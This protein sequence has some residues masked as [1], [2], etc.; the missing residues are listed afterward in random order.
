MEIYDKSTVSQFFRNFSLD[1]SANQKQ[2]ISEGLQRSK[3]FYSKEIKRGKHVVKMLPTIQVRIIV[4]G[5]WQHF[6]KYAHR[7]YRH[8][9]TSMNSQ[10]WAEWTR[11]VPMN[12]T[13]WK[14]KRP[15]GLN[16]TLRTL[17]NWGRL[18][19]GKV[20]FTKEEHTNWLSNV[21]QSA[22]KIYM[23]VTYTLY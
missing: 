4:Y 3:W 15:W 22:L 6:C 2:Q 17:C 13:K 11:T 23:Q 21:Q 10:M 5:D 18:G 7:S 19:K 20:I 14:E 8:G 1:D 16:P 9:L 12:K